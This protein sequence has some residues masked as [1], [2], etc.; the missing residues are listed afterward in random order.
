MTTN[1]KEKSTMK[2]ITVTCISLA[3][4]GICLLMLY[5]AFDLQKITDV[6]AKEIAYKDAK[7]VATDIVDESIGYESDDNTYT[8]TFLTKDGKDFY[9]YEISALNGDILE[10]EHIEYNNMV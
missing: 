8:I 3:A 5:A 7:V 6:Q 4:I 1:N 2:V 10:R 9:E